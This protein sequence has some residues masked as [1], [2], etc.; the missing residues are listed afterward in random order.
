MTVRAQTDFNTSAFRQ[1]LGHFPTGVCVVTS[2]VE[3]VTLGMTVIWMR[4]KGLRMPGREPK[5]FGHVGQSVQRPEQILE[6]SGGGDP[7]ERPGRLVGLVEIAVRD[8]ARHAHQITGL[9]DA[10][11]PIKL[12]RQ[13]PLL[14]ENKL[15]LAPVR[16][17]PRRRLKGL[18]NDL[19][20][21]VIADLVRRAGRGSS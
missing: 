8:P 17:I 13:L 11:H 9:G 4:G 14:H 7:E 19:G 5:D 15:V 21:L 18:A 6:P 20:D 3:G 12:Q 2:V 10:P 16:R 1:A